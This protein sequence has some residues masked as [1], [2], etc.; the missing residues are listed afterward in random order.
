MSLI[1]NKKYEIIEKLGEGAFGKIFLGK[2]IITQEKIAVKLDEGDKTDA[3]QEFH[4]YR[5]HSVDSDKAQE[6][7]K[8]IV[9]IPGGGYGKDSWEIYYD[10]VKTTLSR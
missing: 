1:I 6:I 5:Q 3:L 10:F 4:F 2:N 7:D 9:I 8:P